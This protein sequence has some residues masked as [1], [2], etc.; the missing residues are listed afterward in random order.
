MKYIKYQFAPID[1]NVIYKNS[2][3]YLDSL[4]VSISSSSNRLFHDRRNG[5]INCTI[6]SNFHHDALMSTKK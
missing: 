3:T 5:T 2:Y 1:C 4:S 6:S